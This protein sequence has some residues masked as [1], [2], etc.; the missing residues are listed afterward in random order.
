MEEKR[1]AH[2]AAHDVSHVVVAEYVAPNAHADTVGRIIRHQQYELLASV[3]EIVNDVVMEPTLPLLLAQCDI[4]VILVPADVAV[5][6]IALPDGVETVGVV[7]TFRFK[8]RCNSVVWYVV[9][10]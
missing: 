10:L 8:Q 6:F 1:L 2:F 5:Q 4:P 7:D 9:P 3:V